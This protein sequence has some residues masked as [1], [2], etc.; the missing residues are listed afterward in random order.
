MSELNRRRFL[1]LAGAVVV[2]VAGGGIA[3]IASR[4]SGGQ[5]SALIFQAVTGLPAKPFLSYASY[6]IVGDVDTGN[7][8][9]TITLN[10]Y[11]GP[12]EAITNISLFTRVVRVTSVRQ[13]GN[14][15]HISGVADNPAQ[16]QKGEE[17]SFALQVDSAS[18]IAR[19]TFLG[20]PVQLN[21]QKFSVS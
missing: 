9:G 5:K 12:P 8:S 13:E 14:V 3:F 18:S 7:Q 10:V 21:L 1:V 11:A 19:S 15:W 6:V 20:S 17:T 16:L 2:A 4:L